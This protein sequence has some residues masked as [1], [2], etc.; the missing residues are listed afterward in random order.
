MKPLEYAINSTHQQRYDPNKPDTYCIAFY[1]KKGHLLNKAKINRKDINQLTQIAP[2]NNIIAYIY[3]DKGIRKV[4]NDN[5]K[6]VLKMVK[7]GY[8]Y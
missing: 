6:A 7:D 8:L 2:D 5:I 3:F 4:T 1:H